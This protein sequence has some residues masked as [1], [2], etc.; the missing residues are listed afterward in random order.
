MRGFLLLEG[1]AEFGG[2]MAEA[3]LRAI[4]LA[5]GFGAPIGILPT[6]AAPDN[7]HIRAGENGVRWF[8]HLGAKHVEAINLIDRITAED[9]EI[10]SVIR[11]ARLVY[12]L[13][14]FPGYLA[15]TLVGSA[16]WQAALD[17]YERGAVIAGSSAGAMVLCQHAYDPYEDR[18]FTGLGIIANACVIPHHNRFGSHWSVKLKDS[19]PDYVL[20]G[21]DEQTGMLDDGENRKWRV[22][23]R[24]SVTIYK[25]DEVRNYV[26]G[27][28]FE[29]L[30]T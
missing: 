1:G 9:D 21:I 14:G 16:G 2:Q 17:A 5:G 8:S 25:R 3:D 7:N 13:G 24:G 27:A 6:A 15:E 23:G 20:I 11:S 22:Y 10:A 26:S 19:L 30:P 29:L 18:I 4:H 28:E 12:L